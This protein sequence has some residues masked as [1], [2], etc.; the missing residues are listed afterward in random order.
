MYCHVR[1]LL[2][3]YDPGEP[4]PY[5]PNSLI[6]SSAPSFI[7][8]YNHGPRKPHLFLSLKFQDFDSIIII[9]C[10]FLSFSYINL[11][12][13]M[14]VCFVLF[15]LFLSRI[16]LLFPRLLLSHLSFPRT[17]TPSLRFALSDCIPLVTPLISQSVV[18]CN[19]L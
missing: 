9:Y 19:L 14:W 11:V 13:C 10:Q 6:L 1:P 5:A 4:V 17:L 2:S 7:S 8:S 3:S 18:H 12:C 15:S 16:S